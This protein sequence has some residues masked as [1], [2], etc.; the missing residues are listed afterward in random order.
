MRLAALLGLALLTLAPAHAQTT[1][2][3]GVLDLQLTTANPR[4]AMF[5]QRPSI[6]WT[7]R[8]VQLWIF[9]ALPE[10][11]AGFGGWYQQTIDCTGRTIAASAIWPVT[12]AQ[13]VGSAL[14]GTEKPTAPIT[15]NSMDESISKAL[16]DGAD[17]KFSKPPAT[18]VKTAWDQAQELF[19]SMTKPT[20]P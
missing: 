7:G 16:C 19:R 1:P 9:M 2:P 18:D 10:S 13:A 15:P 20:T 12:K 4:F 6:R 3:T 11:S 14:S 5:F 17:F 8:T